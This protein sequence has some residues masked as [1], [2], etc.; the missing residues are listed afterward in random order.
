MSKNVQVGSKYRSWKLAKKAIEDFQREEC[1][2][3]Y[4]RD[5]RTLAQAKKT[6][7][8]V[9]KEQLKYTFV[10]HSCIFMEDDCSKAGLQLELDHYKCKE[11]VDDE[12]DGGI[13]CSSCLGMAAL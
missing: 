9:V 12:K 6:T 3:F 11:E 7:P 4:V 1:S 5:S 10:M 8:K 13:N 2:Q